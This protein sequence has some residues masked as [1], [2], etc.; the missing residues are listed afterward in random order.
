MFS[1][2]P[3]PEV[4]NDNNKAASSH[5]TRTSQLFQRETADVRSGWRQEVMLAE[6]WNGCR[7]FLRFV[8]MSDSVLPG[9]RRHN[10]HEMRTCHHS[11]GNGRSTANEQS[12]TWFVHIRIPE[13]ARAML[14]PI[15]RELALV[16]DSNKQNT[17]ACGN[18][19]LLKNKTT[20]R[21]LALQE[22]RSLRSKPDVAQR[23]W[24]SQAWAA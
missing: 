17:A 13:Q 8:R 2:G 1:G 14:G 20:K 23:P 15:V 12:T 7:L 22:T 24:E 3:S 4:A 10:V 6:L 18:N 21:R 19:L 9:K 11:H 16:N 5:Y